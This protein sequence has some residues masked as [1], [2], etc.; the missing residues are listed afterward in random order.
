MTP[1]TQKINADDLCDWFKIISPLNNKSR[2]WALFSLGP[3]LAAPGIHGMKFHRGWH[4]S[5]AQCLMN[6]PTPPPHPSPQLQEP[7]RKVFPLKP[8]VGGAESSGSTYATENSSREALLLLEGA[9]AGGP[10]EPPVVE[11]SHSPN[12]ALRALPLGGCLGLGVPEV[13]SS[14][15]SPRTTA[16]HTMCYTTPAIDF[17]I[18]HQIFSMSHHRRRVSDSPRPCP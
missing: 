17:F 7:K 12:G 16:P 4:H 2:G 3:Q 8:R 15:P 10:P 9:G 18:E 6:L 13:P 14:L 5:L 1:R 11:A